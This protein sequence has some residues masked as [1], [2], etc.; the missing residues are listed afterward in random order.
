[1]SGLFYTGLIIL[2]ISMIGWHTLSIHTDKFNQPISYLILNIIISITLTMKYLESYIFESTF[3]LE[4]ITGV[5]ISIFG[6]LIIWFFIGVAMS[7]L[8]D[9]LTNI[10]VIDSRNNTDDPFNDQHAAKILNED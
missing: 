4:I 6:G 9:G 1:M 10:D 7:G 5:I 3:I 8:L 2:Y